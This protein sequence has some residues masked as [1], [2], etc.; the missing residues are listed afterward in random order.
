[1]LEND[2]SFIMGKKTAEFTK[3]YK[4]CITAYNICACQSLKS[5]HTNTHTYNTY[6]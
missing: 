5:T 2:V 3:R 6:I 1:M 4:E